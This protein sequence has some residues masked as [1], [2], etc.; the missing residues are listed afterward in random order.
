V[1]VGGH[2]G[3]DDHSL[4][5]HPV[6]DPGLA[7]RGAGNTYGNPCPA[8]DR[9]R[10]AATSAS[11]SAQIRLTS[12]LEIPLSAPSALTRS[13]TLRV[14]VP[15]RYASMITANSDWPTRRR[16]SSSDGKNDPARSFGIRSPDPRT[17]LD[18]VRGRCPFRHPARPSV[19]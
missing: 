19:R 18:S 8:S 17:V 2:P 6:A 3:G 7:V 4:G 1:P 12:D 15:C 11:R 5:H 16:R 9:S 10:N 13:S 14:E